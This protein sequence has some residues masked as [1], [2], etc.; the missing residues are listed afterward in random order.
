MK[1]II[2]KVIAFLNRLAAEPPFRLFTRVLVQYTPT[3]MQIKARWDAVERPHYLMGVLRA[4]DQAKLEG[5]P[6]IAVIEF[7]VS[8]GEG[9]LLL[10]KYAE[11]VEKE[12]GIGIRIYGFDRGSG[13][14]E[15]S[16]DYRDHPDFY[17]RGD[18]PMNED[19]LRGKLSPR[20]VLFI[21][22]V[23][24]TV[25][26][27]V[28]NYLKVP[29]GFVAIDLDLYTSTRDALIIFSQPG[30]NMLRRVALY[31]DELDLDFGFFDEPVQ[32]PLQR[33]RIAVHDHFQGQDTVS[34]LV[35]E[36]GVR[37]AYIRADQ[38]GAA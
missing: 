22:D 37:L 27:F 8:Y 4:T 19:E 3:S 15:L 24:E 12:T 14:P 10:E 28:S 2:K 25:P 35:E 29:I 20:R 9:L 36:K 32:Q 6:E 16:G 30:K 11:A 21:G 5:V 18:Y 1:R 33:R 13:L 7:G 34:V 26:D 31:F 23:A 17:N 38:I